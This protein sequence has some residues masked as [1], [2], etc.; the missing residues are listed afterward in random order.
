MVLEDLDELGVLTEPEA[1]LYFAIERYL[2]PLNDLF[3]PENLAATEARYING[4]TNVQHTAECFAGE[5]QHVPQLEM[6][7]K[8]RSE[9]EADVPTCPECG[10]D[11]EG[12]H[13]GH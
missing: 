4:K 12:P 10:L 13:P 2:Y 3:R 1:R 11:V 9:F 5:C 8:P 6:Q 7:S